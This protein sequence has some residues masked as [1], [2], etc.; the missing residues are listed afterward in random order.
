MQ[1]WAVEGAAEPR[2][3]NDALHTRKIGYQWTE[4][5]QGRSVEM[6]K[7]IFL[8]VNSQVNAK[9]QEMIQICGSTRLMKASE[10]EV[11]LP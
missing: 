4:Q 7:I 9:P 8:A 1:F 6:N 5:Y 11:L 3:G 10:L 2:Q